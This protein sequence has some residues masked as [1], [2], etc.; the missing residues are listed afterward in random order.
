MDYGENQGKVPSSLHK[1]GTYNYCLLVNY[2]P[3]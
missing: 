3:K 2:L 1:H